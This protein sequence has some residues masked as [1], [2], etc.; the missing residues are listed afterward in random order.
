MTLGYSDFEMNPPILRQAEG[1]A[2]ARLIHSIDISMA[3]TR[4]FSAQHDGFAG[5]D[6][7][8]QDPGCTCGCA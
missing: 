5:T 3:L 1:R 2:M 8:Q 6:D 7:F 4:V